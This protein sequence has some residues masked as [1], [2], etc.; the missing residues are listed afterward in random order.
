MLLSCVGTYSRSLGAASSRILSDNEVQVD[1]N[2]ASEDED[3]RHNGREA[4]NWNSSASSSARVLLMARSTHWGTTRI[5]S[6]GF[7]RRIPMP[8]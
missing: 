1:R 8:E 3:F 2:Y 4:C 5:A 7:L 6:L